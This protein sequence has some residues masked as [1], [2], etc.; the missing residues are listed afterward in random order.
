MGA[1]KAQ[2]NSFETMRVPKNHIMDTININV[3]VSEN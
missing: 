3:L 2:K 1:R